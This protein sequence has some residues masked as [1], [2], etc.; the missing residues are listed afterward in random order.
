MNRSLVFR[1]SPLWGLILCLLLASP[2][3]ARRPRGLHYPGYTPV[4]VPTYGYGYAYLGIPYGYAYNPRR[5]FRRSL[6]YGYPVAPPMAPVTV[7]A[8]PHYGY[9]PYPL[10]PI[11]GPRDYLYRPSYRQPPR[12]EVPT[13]ALAD[14]RSEA[15]PRP[16]PPGSGPE[17]IPTP[18]S[19]PSAGN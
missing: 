14:P 6:R 11:R 7:Y 17:L 3:S 5:A 9:A 2:A 1:L 10:A 13:P 16:A 12:Q 18:P 19:E 8:Y 4:F 15:R